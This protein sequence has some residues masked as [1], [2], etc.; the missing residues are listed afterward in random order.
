MAFRTINLF[1][2]IGSKFIG[3]NELIAPP[4]NSVMKVIV[5]WWMYSREKECKER[6]W[7]VCTGVSM[8]LHE[9]ATPL[10]MLGP[11]KEW[12]MST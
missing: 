10:D 7:R 2:L 1:P 4:R 5:A 3:H 12:D 8:S 6:M 9:N 11:F